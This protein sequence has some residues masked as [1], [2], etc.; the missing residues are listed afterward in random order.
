MT[1]AVLVVLAVPVA[2]LALVAVLT[3]FGEYRRTSNP[4]LALLAVPCF[5]LFW[6]AWYVRDDI[7]RTAR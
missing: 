3:G 6:V 2:V 4:V 7:G 1:T 5:P